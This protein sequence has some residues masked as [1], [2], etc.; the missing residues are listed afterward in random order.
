T[1][2]WPQ[3]RWRPLIGPVPG[4]VDDEGFFHHRPEAVAA[5]ADPA[6]VHD[7]ICAQIERALA[8]GIRPTHL[9]AHMGTAFLPAFAETFFDI[10]HRYGIG[11]PLIRDMSGLFDIVR[12]GAPDTGYLCELIAEAERRSLPVFDRFRIGFTPEGANAGA[13]FRDLLSDSG[14]GLTWF[15]IHANA[16]GDFATIAPHM[17][18]PRES[19]YVLFRETESARVFPTGQAQGLTWREAVGGG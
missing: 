15:A 9:D 7:E 18:Y 1:A 12:L 13:F 10:G 19:E 11:I 6:A 14:S 3:Y 5:R 16:P 17:A 8:D 4:L 2:E